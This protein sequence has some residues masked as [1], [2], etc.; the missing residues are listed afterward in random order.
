M[1][2]SCEENSL[3][4][5]KCEECDEYLCNDCVRAHQRVKMTKDHQISQVSH[6]I[7]IHVRGS[8][9]DTVWDKFGL[10]TPNGGR[11]QKYY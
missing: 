6:L 1:C 5:S 2:Q 3:A 9:T 8:V 7:L 4:N 11:Y 10:W